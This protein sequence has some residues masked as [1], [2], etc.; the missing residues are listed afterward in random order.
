MFANRFYGFKPGRNSVFLFITYLGHPGFRLDRHYREPVRLSKR[1]DDRSILDDLAFGA[2]TGVIDPAATR[3]VAFSL[4]QNYPNPFN[5]TTDFG[6]RIADLGFVS[7]KIY[8]ELGRAVAT[9]VNEVSN[10]VRIRYNGKRREW[11]AEF[12]STGWMP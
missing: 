3:P 6:F 5:P 11:P 10:Q 2:V 8:D 12:I 9:L 7:L 4:S 1:R